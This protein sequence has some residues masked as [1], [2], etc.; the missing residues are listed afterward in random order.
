MPCLHTGLSN[1]QH[2]DRL[3]TKFLSHGSFGEWGTVTQTTADRLCFYILSYCVK[4]TPENWQ[5]SASIPQFLFYCFPCFH[6]CVWCSRRWYLAT[7]HSVL[8]YRVLTE[9]K[10][11]NI[12]KCSPYL[13]CFKDT[14]DS[15]NDMDAI[16]SGLHILIF[17]HYFEF[18]NKK[19]NAKGAYLS[20]AWEGVVG[21]APRFSVL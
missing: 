8:S 17:I 21:A 19:E 4:S 12:L 15:E 2:Y 11:E 16:P 10:E 9:L 6:S 13:D 20:L 5:E 1:S 7:G 3:G 18:N 14:R